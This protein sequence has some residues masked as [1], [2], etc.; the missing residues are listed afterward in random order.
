M[1]RRGRGSSRLLKVTGLVIALAV[2][3]LGLT[4]GQVLAAA[5]TDQREAADAI[6]VLGA[7]QYDG[8]PSPVFQSRLDHALLLYRSGVAPAIAVTGGKQPDDR[9]TEAS[10]AYNYLAERGVGDAAILRIPDGVDT[11]ESLAATARILRERGLDRVVL[12][13]SPMH[14]LRTKVI[15]TELGLSAQISPT[16]SDPAGAQRRL[17]SGA[18]ET[19][20]VAVGRLVGHRRL[21]NLN[22]LL[23]AP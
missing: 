23:L 12:V 15:A 2:A 13:S 3:Y 10:V 6:V 17:R 1:A 21:A 20:A 5:N 8:R 4:A 14:A 22:R 11:W 19:V 7:A 9:W 18:R 16:R